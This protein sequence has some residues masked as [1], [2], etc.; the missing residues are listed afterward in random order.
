[1]DPGE[2]VDVAPAL[3]VMP[4]RDRKLRLVDV[5]AADDHFLD[6][7]GRDGLRGDR[8]P[9]ELHDVLD[10]VAVG[11]VLGIAE[12]K[13]EATDAPETADEELRAASGLVALDTLEE[14]R[15]ALLLEHAARDRAELPIPVHLGLDPPQ[16]PFRVE[17]RDPLAHV[18]EAHRSGLPFLGYPASLMRRAAPPRRGSA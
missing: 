6:G 2:R 4:L 12:R 5:R 18:D 13:R 8:L 7:P 3:E 15:G 9:I 16:L 14:Q 17:P 11:H 10:Q 1:D